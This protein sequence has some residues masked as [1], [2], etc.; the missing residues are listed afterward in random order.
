[1]ADPN[2]IGAILNEIY[3]ISTEFGVNLTEFGV[4]TIE[5]APESIQIVTE[6]IRSDGIAVLIEPDPFRIASISIGFALVLIR[7]APISIEIEGGRMR[8]L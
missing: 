1:M 8:S 7:I 3:P 4:N 5:I 2:E 6:A